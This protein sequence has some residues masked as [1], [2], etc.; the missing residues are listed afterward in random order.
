MHTKYKTMLVIGAAKG[1]GV[2]IT[3]SCI[4]C[5]YNAVGNSL[6]ITAGTLAAMDRSAAVRV[7]I[8]GPIDAVVNIA[9]VFVMKSFAEYTAEDFEKLSGTNLHRRRWRRRCKGRS[10]IRG[11][12]LQCPGGRAHKPRARDWRSN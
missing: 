7:G 6:N 3:N 10:I 5:N 4:E 1:I 12:Q 9:G 11:P 8:G 2:G